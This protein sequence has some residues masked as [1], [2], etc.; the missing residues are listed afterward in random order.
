MAHHASSSMMSPGRVV[1]VLAV[2]V[3][4]FSGC[5]NDPWPNLASVPST[6]HDTVTKEEFEDTVDGLREVREEVARQ[7]ESWIYP[8]P[9]N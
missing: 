5:S 2:A 7:L 4:V 1:L 8:E 3:S 6:P 9:G